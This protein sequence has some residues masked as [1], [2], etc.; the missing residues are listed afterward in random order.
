[1]NRSPLHFSH[2]LLRL[3]SQKLQYRQ[4]FH[5]HRPP[6]SNRRQQVSGP[7]LYQHIVEVN[8]SYVDSCQMRWLGG[9]LFSRRTWGHTTPKTSSRSRL[10]YWLPRWVTPITNALWNA[11]QW[12]YS[13]GRGVPIMLCAPSPPRSR[14]DRDPAPPGSRSD[15]NPAPPEG[16]EATGTPR[17][18]KRPGPHPLGREAS[19]TLLKVAKRPRPRSQ[20]IIP[21]NTN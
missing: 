11:L 1:M 14:S 5:R 20:P 9:Q 15:R 8:V 4:D 2:P 21:R 19:G 10:G 16:R 12:F 13:P 18:R 3:R 7:I 17:P 6:Q